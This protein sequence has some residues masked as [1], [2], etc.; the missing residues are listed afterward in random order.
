MESVSMGVPMIA[1][2]MHSDQPRNA[3]LVTEVLGV[4][5]VV[6]DWSRRGEVLAAAEVAE[7]I[8]RLM[9]AGSEEGAAMRRRATELGHAARGSVAEGGESWKEMDGF[10]APISR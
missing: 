7:G 6:R 10:I 4:G 8:R 9:A 2:P 1:W 3:V 5:A